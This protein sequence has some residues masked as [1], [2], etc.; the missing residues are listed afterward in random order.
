MYLC[1]R[2][3]AHHFLPTYTYLGGAFAFHFTSQAA[4]LSLYC[5]TQADTKK[6][7][8]QKYFHLVFLADSMLHYPVP[9][10]ALHLDALVRGKKREQYLYLGARPH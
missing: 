3:R 5:D 4:F 9:E 10:V 6:S 1:V 8:A 7:Y 2:E